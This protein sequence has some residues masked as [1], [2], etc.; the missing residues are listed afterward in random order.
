[1]WYEIFKFELKYRVRRPETYVFFCFLLL[2]SVFGVDFIF[3]GV[4]L[5]LMKKNAPLV[6]A[7]TMGAITGIFMIMASM[8]MGVPV[9]RDYQYNMEALLFI[10]PI[11][12]RDY[13][14]GRFLGS[15]TVLL[16]VFSGLLLGMIIGSLMPW[17]KEEQMLAFN[18][19]HYLQ[20]FAFIVLPTLF[21][22]ACLFFVS[23]MLSKKLLVVYTQGIFLFVIFMLTKAIA[24]KY[25]QG[26]LDPFSLTT[27]TQFAKDW[28]AL[29][30]NEMNIYFKG[31]LMH[32]KLFWSSLGVLILSFG[33]RKFSF[34]SLAQKPKKQLK[35]KRNSNSNLDKKNNI[36]PSIT[37][38][39]ELKAQCIQLHQLIKFYTLSLLKETSFWAIVICGI[40]IILI[41]SVNL[42]TLYGVDSYPATHFIIAEL[43]EMSMY[44]FIIILLFYS[45]ELVWKERN[46]KMFILNDA[47]LISSII[48]QISKYA[49]LINIYIVIMLSLIF[50]GIMYQTF[51]G[52][53]KFELGVYFFGFFV[54]I[55]PFLLLYTFIAFFFQSISK[56]KFVGII[57][58]LIF[59]ILIN[60]LS[61]F[62]FNHSLFLFGGKVLGSYSEMN[63]YGH[64]LQPY[65][66]GKLYW[67]L[68]GVL[69]LIFSALIMMRGTETSLWKR[70]K[71]VKYQL[72]KTVV[73]T[74]SILL[75]LFI[76]VGGYIFYNTNILNDYWSSRKQNDFRIGY[77]KTLKP[78][79]YIIQPKIIDVQLEVELYPNKRSYEIKGNYILKNTSSDTIYEIHIQKL[80]DSHV[81]LNQVFFEGGAE[82]N[83]TYKKYD[84]IIYK[85]K[86]P[87]HDGDTVKMSFVQSYIPK[88]F[89]EGRPETRIVR[90]GTFF[91]NT[92]LP[93][94]GYNRKYEL[95]DEDDRQV[96][97]LQPR[98]KKAKISNKKE[99]VN[100]RS[101]GDSDGINL[102]VIIGT[103][104]KQTAVT[105]GELQ[106][107][108]QNNNRNYY[109]YKTSTPIINFFSIVSAEYET[110]KELWSE[111]IKPVNL[112][113]YYHKGHEYN[114][115]RMMDGMKESLRYFSSNFTPYQYNQLRIMEFPRYQEFAQSFPSA[116]P[117]SEA[118]GFVLDI[119][120]KTDVDM[121]FYVTAHEVAHQWFGMQIEAANVQGRNFVLE[122]LSQYAAIMVLKKKY[123]NKKVKQFLAF[124][125][126]I[127]HREQKKVTRETPLLLVEEQGF[128]Y[129]NKGAI[130]MYNLQ[131]MIGEERVNFALQSFIKDWNTKE[132]LLKINTK[133]YPTS[134]DV[135]AYFK[136]VT[137]DKYQYLISDLF[138]NVT[139]LQ[140]INN[141]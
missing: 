25:L 138:E 64:L 86:K 42:G 3:Q 109:H 43:Q 40:I 98:L 6:I 114:L 130:A 50:M 70:F 30:R 35:L 132:G 100:S 99:L 2:F 103:N 22:G 57:F 17:H 118:L 53:Y 141:K 56:N 34:S 102:E 7:K 127:Y 140:I 90:N 68:F 11:L 38:N 20:S 83:D 81:T 5:G 60:V 134:K 94:L 4:E 65:L 123:G 19:F 104:K 46:N 33:Y 12:K 13:L 131:E 84:Y 48:N 52:Y 117:F 10:N 23:G 8:I 58:T 79:E 16:F 59:F 95:T 78:I 115:E 28:T 80:L 37:I 89:E 91:D 92:V 108:W 126:D 105:S 137:P 24:N 113:I 27:L 74:T 121:A 122:T 51:S 67:I 116:I 66:W 120:N 139:P 107:K 101:G 72:T 61:A 136:K 73:Y 77:E 112:E 31:I 110:K 125:K 44:F 69:L 9:L 39:S 26:I 54:E 32:S 55:L 88:G 135:L 133:R 129:Y 21:F 85:L 128:V 49:A 1:M 47:T 18:L 36:I 93:T 29:E 82:V 62:G 45:G 96:N 87:L 75:I 111:M 119:N 14:L 41:N 124:Q 97:G 106:R 63:G 15:F 71:D 76:S